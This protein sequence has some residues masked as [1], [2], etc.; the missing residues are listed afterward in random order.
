MTGRRRHDREIMRLALP[1]LGALAAEPAVALVDTAFVGRLGA[2]ALGG[3]GIAAVPFAWAFF[4][5][6]FL[7]YATTPLVA[8]AVGAGRGGRA[9]GIS[10]TAFGVAVVAGVAVA[11][12]LEWLA[13]PLVSVVGGR[14]ETADAAVTYLRIRAL[15]TP[16]VL[17]ILAGNGVLRGLQDTKT[18]LV[19]TV[20]L[21]AI[22]LVLDPIL[23]F[24]LDMGVA[25]A[26]WASVV[27]QW[28]GGLGFAVVVWRRL[29]IG[30]RRHAQ[31]LADVFRFLVAGVQVGTRTAAL[32]ATSS[33][34]TAVAARVGTVAVAAHQVT[35]QL[36]LFLALVVDALAVAAQA[37]VGRF[38]GEER[39]GEA[40][41]L[42]R[43][44]L[45]LGLGAGLVLAGL[46]AALAGPLPRWFTDD[47]EVV[48]S[49]R[50]VYVFVVAL[51]PVNA[52]VFV[53][54]GIVLGAADFRYTAVAMVVSSVVAIAVLLLV[55]PLGWGLAGV[56]VGMSALM[57][58][59]FG[60]LAWW[61]R[62]FER[63][64]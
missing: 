46:M 20:G 56:W 23:I 27:A 42:S 15:A 25:G 29:D 6:N 32:L 28:A 45:V 19:I 48:S 43:R 14:G 37:M 40:V 36:W 44:L 3:V 16:A 38:I 53:W 31:G 52:L 5:F 58:A 64:A 34:A 11:A 7:S 1:A 21:S 2:E 18:P 55:L 22:N 62:R 9:A 61:Q 39:H 50:T 63:P 51:Q 4:A 33:V 60:T 26:A 17:A 47:P 59:R 41:A 49:I 54:D 24:G 35:F 30:I 13:E 10:V 8:R 57:V 12:A